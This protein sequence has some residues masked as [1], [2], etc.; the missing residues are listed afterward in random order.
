MAVASGLFF[1]M[2]E[3]SGWVWNHVAIV[4]ILFHVVG[5]ESAH[6]DLR[7]FFRHCFQHYMK[8]RIGIK[9]K[10]N[11]SSSPQDHPNSGHCTHFERLSVLTK[12]MTLSE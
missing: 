3:E 9:S 12:V 1:T 4:S 11:K 6:S 8:T 2:L 5:G 10:C 7:R